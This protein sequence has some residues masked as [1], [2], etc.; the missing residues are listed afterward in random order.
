MGTTVKQYLKLDAFGR[1]EDGTKPTHKETYETIVN[2]IGLGAFIPLMP[3]GLEQMKAALAEDQHLNNIPLK[4]WDNVTPAAR[5][6][7]ARIGITST[8]LADGVCT[9]KAAARMWVEE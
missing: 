5:H 1:R 2:D 6:L 9:L 3:V 7:M 4:R 8:S